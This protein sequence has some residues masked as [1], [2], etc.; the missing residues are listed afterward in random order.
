MAVNPTWLLVIAGIAG[1]IR[2]I[3]AGLATDLSLLIL[4]QALHAFTFGATH[5]SAVHF[6]QRAAPQDMSASAQSL[7]SALGSGVGFG[8]MMPIAGYLYEVYGPNAFIFM[9]AMAASGTSLALFLIYYW[10][11]ERLSVN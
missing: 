9:A 10:D 5:L 11:G 1:S 8:I 7:Y 6:I 4:C 2:W 3:V